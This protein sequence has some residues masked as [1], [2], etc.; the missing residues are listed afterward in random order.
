MDYSKTLNLPETAFSMKSDAAKTESE[1]LGIW[2]DLN[3]YERRQRSNKGKPKFIMHNPPRPAC[4]RVCIDDALNMIL[5]DIIVKYKLMRGFGV[6]HFPSW[7]CYTPAVEREALQLLEGDATAHASEARQSEVR[8]LCRS[9]CSE[10]VAFQKKQFQRLGIFAYWDKVTLNPGSRMGNPAGRSYESRMIEAFGELYEAGYLRKGAKPTRWCI[11]CQTD[12]AEAETEY[13][14]CKLL[15]LYV[16]FPVLHGLEE[17]GEDVYMVV[18]T[19]I[20]WTLPANTAIIVHPDHDYVAV[21]HTLQ[22]NSEI[23]IMAAAAAE[24]TLGKTQDTKDLSLESGVWSLPYRVVRKM[25][26][27]EL[28]E[29]VYA[30]PFLDR[31]SNV[32]LDR[33]V[34]LARGTGCVHAAQT[35]GH[36][37]TGGDAVGRGDSAGRPYTRDP[38]V[39]SAV[40]QN[41]QLT[42]EAG[43]FCGLNVFESGDA[44]S[45]ELEKRGC[46]LASEPVE[47]PYPHCTYCKKPIIVRVAD[48]WI[49][50]LSASNLRQ[51]VLE[52]V[53]EVNW[54][55]GWS[56]NR[57]F[58]TIDRGSDWSVSRQRIWGI[59][60]PVF[61]CSKCGFQIDILE[62]INA[63]KSMI[64]RK[65]VNRWLTARPGDILPEDVICDRCGGRDFRWETE[66][67][68]TEF[69]SAMSYKAIP[70]NEEVPPRDQADI[71]LGSNGQNEKWFQFSLLPSIAIEGSPPFKSVLVHGSV[72]GEDGKRIPDNASP[73]EDGAPSIQDL[74]DRF[75]AD[76]LRFWATSMDCRKHLRM[77]HSCLELVSKVYRRVR[78][79]CRFLLGNLSGYDPESDRLDYAYLQEV[80]RWALHRLAKFTG[81]TTKALEDCQFH[82]FYRV[83]YNFC[84]VDMSSIYLNMVKRRLYTFPRWSSSRRAV[85]TVIYEVLTSLTR[86]IAPVLSF[87]AEEIWRHIPGVREDC[88]S[89]Y[90]SHWPGV[91]EDFLDDELESRWNYLLKIRSEMRKLLEKIRQEEGISSTSQASIIL[92]ASLPDVYDLLDRYID[93]LE[94]IFMVSKVRLMPPDVPVPDGIWESDS[95]KGLAIEIRRATG[96]KCER[97]WIYSDTV[98]TNEQ[99]PTLCYQCIA[100]LEGGTYYV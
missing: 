45:L 24:D 93:D 67:L 42:E 8:K 81:T 12:L 87:T 18:W 98:G 72:L 74:L 59:P 82:V 94:A 26:G 29:I 68:D 83:L 34:S 73:S 5:K 43:Q 14:D 39:I 58:D 78:N 88:P 38:K 80:D 47:Q 7:N 35:K 17:L 46:L 84:S 100:I 95:I 52:V 53:E 1:V 96:E 27:L 51:R 92:Y 40:D 70:T 62:G 21:E 25:K 32:I 54:L 48:K 61:Y 41:G 97:C 6:P 57:V 22:E 28:G 85:Q 75:G 30:H 9:L 63:S 19:N 31:N 65:G 76:I 15:S 50:D 4:G 86:L 11:N 2:K 55:P 37:A 23:L 89:V 20:P 36:Y 79:I 56:K 33:R 90:L 60:A 69:I 16:K 99:Y 3:I 49:F 44:I 64:G 71:C 91:N 66:I 10:Y 13:R 77:S